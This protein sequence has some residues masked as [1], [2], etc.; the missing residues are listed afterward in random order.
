ME[1]NMKLTFLNK[2]YAGVRNFVLEQNFLPR[3]MV[4]IIDLSL[5]LFA[6]IITIFI[7]RSVPITTPTVLTLIEKSLLILVVQLLCFS[8]FR[9]YSGIIRHSTFT[10]VYRIALASSSVFLLTMVGNNAYASYTGQHV[11]AGTG[12]LL[13]TCLS[14]GLLMAFRILVKETYRFLSKTASQNSKKRILVFGVSDT[15]IGLA[16]SLIGDAHSPYRPVAFLS[17]SEKGHNFKIMDLPIL[18]CCGTIENDLK[19][20]KEK[21]NAQGVLLVGDTLS[22][23]EKNNIVEKTFAAGLEVYNTFMPEKWDKLS[24][25]HLK[26]APLQIEDLL[27]RDPIEIDSNLIS[28]D[29]QG[30]TILVTGG[31]GSIGGELAKQIAA[32]KP[33]K[34]IVLDNAESALHAI[35]LHLKKNFPKLKYQCY[36]ADV[37]QKGR[38]EGIFAKFHFDVVYHAAA[39]KHVPM[40][41]NHPREGIRINT[42]GTRIV[43]KLACDYGCE[44]FVMISTDKAVNPSNVMG[45]TKRAAEMYVQAL[46]RKPGVTTKFVTTRFGNVLGSNGSVIPFFKEQI[47]NGGPVTVTHKDIIRYF[48]TIQEACQL[49]LQ[50]GTMGKG[51]EIFVFDMGKPVRILDMAER[52]IKL[53]G[54]KPYDDIP[55]EITGLREGEKLYEELLNAGECSLTTFHPKIMVS[56]VVEY[57]YEYISQ[58]LNNLDIL[59]NKVVKKREIIKTLKQLVPEFKS[60]NSVYVDLDLLEKPVDVTVLNGHTLPSQKPKPIHAKT[61][62]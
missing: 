2:Q 31:A 55:I 46:Q 54:L 26:I 21:Y 19:R 13:Y 22:V 38:M 34:M 17:T 9:T 11:F 33:K 32:F 57:D 42:M 18:T 61:G 41:E 30:K 14:F 37:T 44:R 36:L 52:M 47:K 15:S 62:N 23:P 56:G 5:C 43:A 6:F 59:I 48:M 39:Y 50:A 45:A 8:V 49:V 24:D 51:G 20:I 10:D 12:L 29:L 3:W 25:V 40:I 28:S 60:Q 1:K 4:V 7:L 16:Q 53:S 58:A 27:E 35:D